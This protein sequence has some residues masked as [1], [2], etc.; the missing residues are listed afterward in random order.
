M[1]KQVMPVLRR[2]LGLR[3][4]TVLNMI[5]MVGIGPFTALPIILIAF[6]G[7]FSLIP[8]CIGAIISLLDGFIWSELGSAWP[9]AGGSYIFL[10]EL[11]KGKTGKVLSFLYIVQTSF[12]T[13]LVV[14]SACLGFINYFS[15]ILPLT[16]VQGKV[17]MICVVIVTIFLLYRNI[18]NVGKIGFMLSIIVIGMLL[19]TIVTGILAFDTSIFQ[20]NSL[21]NNSLS[22]ISGIS[23]WMVTG[24]YTTKSIYAYLGYY[25][26]CHIGSEIKQPGKNI[27]KSI[28]ISIAG[29][30]VLYISM[31][32]VM[33]GAIKQNEI[34]N[35][36]VPL[37][38]LLFEHVYGKNF[39]IIASVLLLIVA[40]SSLFALL[41]GYT[42]II[43]AASM[44]G[45]HLKIFQHLHPTKNF[46]DYA[47]LIF[48]SIAI[49][50]CLVF[51]KPSDVFRFIVV[52]RIFIQFI[53]QVVGLALMRIKKRTHELNYK[54]P[55][56]PIISTISILAWLFVFCTSGY[57]Y[58]LFGISIILLGL[59]IYFLY[60][61]KLQRKK[62]AY[63]FVTESEFKEI[64][65]TS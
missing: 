51:N 49:V 18:I 30:A 64:I 6:P 48:G 58:S 27:P 61:D 41:L 13:P 43:Y 24:M 31:Q 50:S 62:K 10:Q 22:S 25:N 17:V 3:H 37:V 21:Q 63:Q 54:M 45:M 23:F 8:W 1:E 15:Y 19:W 32:L 59:L 5:D 52:T 60:I 16:F 28:F 47:L 29:I 57:K 40:A 34:V 38:S 42:R 11:F 2:D 65:L 44:E 56:F 9:K 26:V 39:G 33:A 55:F 20:I 14:T 36:N 46:P 35:E 12:H 4:A 7:K 53:P